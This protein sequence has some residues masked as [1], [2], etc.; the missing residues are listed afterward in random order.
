MRTL[1]STVLDVL[2]CDSAPVRSQNAFFADVYALAFSSRFLLELPIRGALSQSRAS[3][4]RGGLPQHD[5]SL[6]LRCSERICP[7]TSG[8]TS[9]S[10]GVVGGDRAS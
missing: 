1:H 5:V 3:H 10:L 9:R 6:A 4:S 7:Y 2:A 8:Q